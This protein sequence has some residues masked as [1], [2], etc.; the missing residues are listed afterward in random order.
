MCVRVFGV[1]TERYVIGTI[2]IAIVL[3]DTASVLS[4]DS[5]M[6]NHNNNNKC[7]LSFACI[8]KDVCTLEILFS[9]LTVYCAGYGVIIVVVVVTVLSYALKFTIY[10]IWPVKKTDFDTRL[11]VS[12]HTFVCWNEVSVVARRSFAD[13]HTHTHALSL[14]LSRALSQRF[15]DFDKGYMSCWATLNDQCWLCDYICSLI[16]LLSH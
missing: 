6:H 4:T 2:A 8:P 13:E 7:F 15:N 11:G 12:T 10:Y 9:L 1:W 5:W 16:A 3:L 14:F